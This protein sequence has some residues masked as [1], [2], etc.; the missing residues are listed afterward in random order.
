MD[1]HVYL[2][3]HIFVFVCV[4]LCV[5]SRSHTFEYTYLWVCT[6]APLC[7]YECMCVSGGWS[8]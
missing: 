7:V 3:A 2:G 6:H 1:G 8:M 4:C 5:Y